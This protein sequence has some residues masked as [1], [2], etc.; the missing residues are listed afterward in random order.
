[1]AQLVELYEQLRGE[2][3]PVQVEDPEVALQHNIGIGRFA[4]GSVGCVHILGR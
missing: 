4:T 2:A 3:G 1:V